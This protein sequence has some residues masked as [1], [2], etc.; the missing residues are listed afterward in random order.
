MRPGCRA[1]DL[2]YEFERYG[3]LIRCD[4]PAPS[5]RNGVLPKTLYAFV[6]FEDS[7][8]AEKALKNLRGFRFGGTS[9]SVQVSK[10]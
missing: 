7:R 1:R 4:I 3:R 6:E 9:I 10:Y 5:M 8:D 2:A